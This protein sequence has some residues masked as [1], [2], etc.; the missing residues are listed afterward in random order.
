M[1]ESD[2]LACASLF[3][4]TMGYCRES[5]IRHALADQPSHAWVAVK[6]DADVLM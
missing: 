4:R 3:E 6:K 1:Q 5:E 2:V